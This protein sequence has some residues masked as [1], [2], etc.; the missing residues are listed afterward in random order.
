LRN[1][2][3][4][5]PTATGRAEEANPDEHGFKARWSTT[6]NLGLNSAW[7]R[8]R[9]RSRWRQRV[10]MAMLFSYNDEQQHDADNKKRMITISCVFAFMFACCLQ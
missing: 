2:T 9:D 5:S 6:F 1:S 7:Q 4:L 3:S 8:A 10:G